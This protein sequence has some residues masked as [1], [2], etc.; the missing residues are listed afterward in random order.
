MTD[1]ERDDLRESLDR[2]P[3]EIPPERNLWPEVAR[4]IEASR[5]RART[6]RTITM[7]SS[8]A[9]AAARTSPQRATP[10]DLRHHRRRMF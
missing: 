2:L 7:A 10:S 1:H 6:L 8:L 4:R 3:R 9:A 5:R